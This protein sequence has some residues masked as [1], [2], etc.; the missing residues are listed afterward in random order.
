MGRGLGDKS[1]ASLSFNT[2][3]PIPAVGCERCRARPMLAAFVARSV[4]DEVLPPVFLVDPVI[5]R[6]GGDIVEQVRE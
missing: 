1:A 3:V 5:R 2:S 4:V 6:V